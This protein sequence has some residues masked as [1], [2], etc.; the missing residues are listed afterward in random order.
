MFDVIAMVMNVIGETLCFIEMGE[1]RVHTWKVKGNGQVAALIAD[2]QDGTWESCD[3][4]GMGMFYTHGQWDRLGHAHFDS[5]AF[6]CD[7][8]NAK[9]YKEE[10]A[11]ATLYRQ[12]RIVTAND[13]F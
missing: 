11:L 5:G 7:A 13:T 9:L 12:E 1:L 6:F 3:L 10:A 2:L 8:C 4:C